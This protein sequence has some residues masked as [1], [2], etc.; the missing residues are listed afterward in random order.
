MSRSGRFLHILT[1]VDQ[2]RGMV[3]FY[4][5]TR[6]LVT[7]RSFGLPVRCPFCRQPDPVEDEQ[8]IRD[9]EGRAQPLRAAPLLSRDK[10]DTPTEWTSHYWHCDGLAQRS[11]EITSS[12]EGSS[13]STS[14]NAT[15]KI[16]FVS[17]L[18]RLRPTT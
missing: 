1:A 17:R 6:P 16:A 3:S 2:G 4:C 13:G 18:G 8:T 15:S 11:D 14:G 10:N 12:K 5:E 7:V 9:C